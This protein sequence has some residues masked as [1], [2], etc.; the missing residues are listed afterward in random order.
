M[1]KIIAILI[2]VCAVSFTAS[3]QKQK[4]DVV[5]NKH[6]YE[7]VKKDQKHQKKIVGKLD[8]KSKHYKR[9]K[10]H[11]VRNYHK[12][13][14]AKERRHANLKKQGKKKSYINRPY[15]KGQRKH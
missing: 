12:S 15:K 1:K 3:A 6:K 10:K 2:A 5:V 4:K 14:L 8:H 7:L 9:G 11:Q 13:G